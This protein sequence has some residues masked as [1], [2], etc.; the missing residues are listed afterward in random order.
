MLENARHLNLSRLQMLSIMSLADVE[1]G[2]A[3]LLINYRKF[4]TSAAKMIN[5]LFDVNEQRVRYEVRG[6]SDGVSLL[7]GR[8]AT[9]LRQGGRAMTAGEQVVKKTEE[10]RTV[11]LQI[12]REDFER[13]LTESVSEFDPKRSGV[14][15]FPVFLMCLQVRQTEHNAHELRHP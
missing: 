5:K 15:T 13:R 6:I 12:T 1:V 4:A 11:A 14:V 8:V 10:T 7:G 9:W 3:S 2:S